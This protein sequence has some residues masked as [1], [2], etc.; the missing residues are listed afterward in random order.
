LIDCWT[1][2]RGYILQHS[3]ADKS[4]GINRH[5]DYDTFIITRASDNA[6]AVFDLEPFE[7]SAQLF[8]RA[9]GGGSLISAVSTGM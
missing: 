2:K 3:A 4:T 6:R 5:S 1:V 9:A 7:Q 8:M